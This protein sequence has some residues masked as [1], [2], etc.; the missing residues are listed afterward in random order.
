MANQA[1]YNAYPKKI[2]L[3]DGAE[4]ELR[5]M[6]AADRNAVLAF[7]RGL[8]QEDLMFLRVD[9]TE[10]SVVDAWV[11][12]LET[13]H[14][15]SIVAY[16]SNGLIGYA[17]VH[18][19]PTSWT[20]H[21]G[22][23]R[24]NVDPAYRS[25]GLGRVLTANIFDISRAIGLSKITAHMT[26]DQRGAQAAFRHLGFIPEALLADYVQDRNG[27]TRDMVIMSFDVTGHTDQSSGTLK[28]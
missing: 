12:N 18:R 21:M 4:V 1:E 26:S 8:P 23:I 2:T 16:D 14:T 25:R 6:T 15:S 20:R 7:A 11:H 28:V 5:E 24:V 10:D 9:L 22:E 3:P 17:S 27:T 13:G 19:N